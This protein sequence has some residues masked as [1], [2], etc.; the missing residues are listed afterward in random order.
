MYLAR[1]STLLLAGLLAGPALW[2]AFVQ[3][4]LDYGTAMTRFLVAVVVSGLMLAVL[5]SMAD[6][7][8][9][10]KGGQE[11]LFIRLMIS[12]LLRD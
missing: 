1:W 4:D 5:R 3:G 11:S 9:W 7:S 2:H 8:Q 12:K 10:I 6:G